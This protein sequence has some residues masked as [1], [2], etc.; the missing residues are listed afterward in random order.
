MRLVPALI[1]DGLSV[2]VLTVFEIVATRVGACRSIPCDGHG[3][4][5][6]LVTILFAARSQ[7][8]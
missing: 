5:T 7:A 1:G 4:A 2:Q 8:A 6:I 3:F